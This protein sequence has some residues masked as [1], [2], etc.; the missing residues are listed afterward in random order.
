M[1]LIRVTRLVGP[2]A[3]RTKL[4]FASRPYAT[5]SPDQPTIKATASNSNMLYVAL[6]IAA[7]A[8]GY[9]YYA[10][11]DDVNKAEKKV[12]AE[13]EDMIRKGRDSVDSAKARAGDAY[14]RG[15]ARYDE[16]KDVGQDKLTSARSNVDS[17]IQE[18]ERRARQTG[19]DIEAKYDSYKASAQKSLADARGSTENLYKEARSMADRKA[20]EVRS[21]VEK[22]GD[23]V[24]A[25]W[26]NWLGW[27]KSEAEKG[28]RDA[29]SKIADT[30]EDVKQQADK[31]T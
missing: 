7:A 20:T 21:D 6:G 17:K 25:G 10:H 2:S 1:A 8:G 14:Q 5:S 16:T 22:K 29:A 28:K 30:A 3:P 19:A 9:W 27:G 23:Q 26:S 11:P 13:E 15:Q 18:A 31:Q 24:N 4:L 12:K